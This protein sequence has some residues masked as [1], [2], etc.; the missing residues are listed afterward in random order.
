[1]K[2]YIPRTSRDDKKVWPYSKG[3]ELSTKTAYKI[4]HRECRD[5]PRFAI[6]WKA[7]WRLPLPLRVLF[8][9]WKCLNNVIQV[10]KLLYDKNIS[11]E[12]LCPICTKAEESVE[13]ALFLCDHA[14]AT[15]FESD[16]GMFSHS[17]DPPTIR[18]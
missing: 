2:I 17:I 6:N 12:A 18:D 13:H 3:D 10:H 8:F 7:L 14:R 9:G 11:N 16:I 4:I 1:M 15:W 5:S